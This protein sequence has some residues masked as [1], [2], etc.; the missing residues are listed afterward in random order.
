MSI[1][2]LHY[3][4]IKL[5]L[6][7]TTALLMTFVYLDNILQILDCTEGS[8]ATDQPYLNMLFGAR[9]AVVVS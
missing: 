8:T 2:V 6:T 4:H 1:T 7:I 3:N 9:V 5:K